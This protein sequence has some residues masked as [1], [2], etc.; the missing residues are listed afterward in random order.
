M[1]RGNAREIC[2]LCGE[3]VSPED[4]VVRGFKQLDVAHRECYDHYEEEDV[5]DE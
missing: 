5:E 2:V 3:I 4:R 1:S